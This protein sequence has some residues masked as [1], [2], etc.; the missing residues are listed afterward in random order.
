MVILHA[1]PIVILMM[2]IGQIC[3]N[4]TRLVNLKVIRILFLQ[5]S[6]GLK[7]KSLKFI[8]LNSE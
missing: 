1:T 8:R 2:I 5:D 3:N 4:M 6:T 7:F